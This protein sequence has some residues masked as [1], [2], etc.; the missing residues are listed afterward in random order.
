MVLVGPHSF[1]LGLISSFHILRSL[2]GLKG[3]FYLTQIRFVGIS[4][5]TCRIET[6]RAVRNVDRVIASADDKSS[7][8][9][10]PLVNR[11]K[12]VHH[13]QPPSGT[14]AL[15]SASASFQEMVVMDRL[16]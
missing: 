13:D 15:G 2:L 8:R 11:L 10:G 14:P 6:P 7:V 16:Q 5:T 1:L 4:T 3:V 9:S 12:G